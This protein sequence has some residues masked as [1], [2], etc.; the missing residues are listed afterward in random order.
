MGVG[1]IASWECGGADVGVRLVVWG[2]APALDPISILGGVPLLEG[3]A[4]CSS[5]AQAIELTIPALLVVQLPLSPSIEP[6]ALILSPFRAV[7]SYPLLH[8]S[9]AIP[10]SLPGPPLLPR[11]P[12]SL[13]HPLTSSPV[14]SRS[15]QPPPHEQVEHTTSPRRSSNSVRGPRIPFTLALTPSPARLDRKERQNDRKTTTW[16]CVST[17]RVERVG[18][19]LNRGECEAESVRVVEQAEVRERCRRTGC[20]GTAGAREEDSIRELGFDAK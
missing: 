10:R 20:C 9:F 18:E 5:G 2:G 3:S 7:Q 19:R 6:H 4:S 16:S 13:S 11:N 12:S 1:A 8:P 17:S 15:T 14:L